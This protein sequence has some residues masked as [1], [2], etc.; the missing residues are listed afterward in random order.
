MLEPPYMAV[1]SKP[2]AIFWGFGSPT[3]WLKEDLGGLNNH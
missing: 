1:D 2:A 3:L